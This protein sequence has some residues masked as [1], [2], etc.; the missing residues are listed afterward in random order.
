MI[1]RVPTAER[2]GLV[3]FVKFFLKSPLVDFGVLV[4]VLAQVD[5]Q[6]RAYEGRA[7]DRHGQDLGGVLIEAF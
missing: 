6:Q 1:Q 7:R 5:H 2:I 4:A 3:D